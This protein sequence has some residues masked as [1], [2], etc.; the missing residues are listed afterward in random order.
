M[1]KTLIQGA[2]VLTMDE[3]LGSLPRGDVLIDGDRIAAVGVGLPAEGA[4][5]IDGENRIVLPG[6]ADTHRHMWAAMLRGC[7]CKPTKSSRA[8]DAR[9]ACLQ[10]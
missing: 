1:G 10:G 6:F 3:R 5:V 2:H 9:T 8:H 7:A 4:D